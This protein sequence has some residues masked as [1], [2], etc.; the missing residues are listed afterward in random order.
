MHARQQAE[1]AAWLALNSTAIAHGS[2]RVEGLLAASYWS[3]SKSRLSRWNAALKTFDH[4]VRNPDTAHNPWPAIET[5][6]EEVVVSEMLT[7]VWSAV[8]VAVDE[9]SGRG[10]LAGLAHSV[11][12]GHMEA[13]NRAMR[14]L[15]AGR[16]LNE[17][18]F[19]RI[20]QLRRSLEKWTDLFL[21]WIPNANVARRFAFDRARFD[22]YRSEH[23]FY[24]DQQQANRHQVLIRSMAQMLVSLTGQWT[25]NPELNRRIVDGAL[26]CI[27]RDAFD[28]TGLPKTL[29]AVWI[30]RA[31]SDAQLFVSQ[32]ELLDQGD[33]S[34]F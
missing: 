7:R 12:I 24:S 27:D 6:V 23:D 4:D 1:I 26:A 18:L 13:R 10:E 25:A 3:N 33:A 19:D 8:L 20:N 32:L 17:R 2:Q 29:A 22:D 31:H 34:R 30:E 21:A 28:S 15:L 14:L 9:A 16:G 5:V 11:Y